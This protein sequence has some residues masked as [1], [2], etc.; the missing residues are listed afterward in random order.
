VTDFLVIAFSILIAGVVAVPLATRLRLGSVLGYLL[1][2]MA[3]SPLLGFLEVDLE[4]LQIF[5]EF[6]VVMMLFLVG[7][8]LEPKRLWDMRRRLIGMGGGQVVL[9]TLVI[10]AIALI[11]GNDWRTAM[12]IGMVLALSST[13]I[14][15][16]TLR[17][18]G[19]LRSEG[20]EASFSVLLVQ[21]VA[22]IPIL[23]ILPLLAVPELAAQSGG[24][25]GEGAHAAAWTLTGNMP[26]W[27]AGIVTVA[28]VGLVV[29]IGSTLTRPVF[30]FI[31]GAQLRELFTGT[32]LMFVIGI[33]LLMSLVGLSPALGTFLAGVVLA[34]SEYRHEL[35]A[36]IE[37]FKGLLLGLFFI[38]VGA[39]VNFALAYEQ[40]GAVLFWTALVIIAKIAVL[41]LIARL[42]GVRK[43]AGWLFALSLAQAGEFAFVLIGIATA[44]FVFSEPLAD[45]LLLVVALSMLVTPLLF[46]LYDR[47]IAAAYC[48]GEDAP[49][50][51]ID[52]VHPIIIAGRG[53]V[54]GIVDRILDA[55]GHKATVID[56]DS[57]HLENLKKF[58]IRTY[59]GDATRPDLLESAG[60]AHARLLVVALDSKEQID[61]LVGYVART[62]PQVHITARAVDRDHVYKLWA[63]GCRDIIRE[64]YDASLRIGRSALEA[65]G[66]DRQS[67]RA[68]VDAFEAMDRSSMRALADLY[69]IDLPA[70]ENE[71]LIAKV[72]ELRSEWDPK[73]REQIDEILGRSGK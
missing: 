54:G 29:F 50:D 44:S 41:A 53:R 16:Q 42:A 12:A 24:G 21:D 65:L 22:V 68:I 49:P 4:R 39:G 30:R 7:L 33:A 52:E 10:A 60:I 73:L 1:A 70:H 61:R 19:L 26:A 6:G 20:G 58:G 18:K 37:P 36:D 32:A 66:H 17:E 9:T 51:A 56:H 47:L 5:A 38:T 14:I 11:Y 43:Q 59:F 67:A 57:R 63:L 2:G 3:L 48:R 8:E 69:Q 72:R 28:A 25:T 64:T 35:E 27:L 31:A 71:P 55:A 15:V 34:N 62:Y 13:A 45:L 46:I 40:I 23:A